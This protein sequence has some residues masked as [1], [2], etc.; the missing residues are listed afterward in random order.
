[1][2][3]AVFPVKPGTENEVLSLCDEGDGAGLCAYVARLRRPPALQTREAEPFVDCTAVVALP[4][5]NAATGV[6]D[7][8]Y[9]R[10]GDGRWTEVHELDDDESIVRATL[11]LD[12]DRLT[13]STHSEPR[14]ERVLTALDGAFPGIKVMSDERSPVPFPTMLRG[15]A[16]AP[17]RLDL[18]ADVA[19]EIQDK[20]E[21]RWLTEHVPALGGLTPVEAVADPSRVEQVERLI[22]SWSERPLP[23]GSITMRPDRLRQL[24]GLPAP[25]L[26]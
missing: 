3:G 2:I 21:R 11:V 8:L 16:N 15:P 25:E 4:D 13:I 14:L 6:L 20:M 1:L 9:Q 7:D 23:A 24:L 26:E 5:A 22:A 18:P 12:G 17:E 19:E 10:E